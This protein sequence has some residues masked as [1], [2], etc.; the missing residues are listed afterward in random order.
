M[1]SRAT[2][3]PAPLPLR[4]PTSKRARASP[5][6]VRS[7]YL[8]RL[9]SSLLCLCCSLHVP[10]ARCGSG[11]LLSFALPCLQRAALV[12]EHRRPQ[13]YRLDRVNQ[14]CVFCVVLRLGYG[15][16]GEEEYAGEEDGGGGS[17]QGRYRF[18]LC[19]VLMLPWLP[20]SR[21]SVPRLLLCSVWL[22]VVP[23]VCAFRLP[24]CCL[25]DAAASRQPRSP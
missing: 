14:L 16:Q 24:P 9:C 7:V 12:F 20:G 11:A 22:R 25:D 8:Q 15:A 10:A 13:R 1:V 18:D 21:W 17:G 5:A 23:F 6:R 2:A 4:R 19:V 3:S